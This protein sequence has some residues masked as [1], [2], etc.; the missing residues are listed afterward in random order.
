M[1]LHKKWTR[2]LFT[3][4]H[5][6]RLR[7]RK[8]L[9]ASIKGTA[10]CT[11]PFEKEPCP[12]LTCLRNKQILNFYKGLQKQGTISKN[13]LL[14]QWWTY[15]N[16]KSLAVERIITYY[17][18]WIYFEEYLVSLP[19]PPPCRKHWMLCFHHNK[20]YEGSRWIEQFFYRSNPYPTFQRASPDITKFSYVTPTNHFNNK[21]LWSKR[22]L[23]FCSQ[24]SQ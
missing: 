14:F 24:T 21:D 22:L 8:Q 5:Q 9:R 13:N 19:L 20:I 16:T 3:A 11:G 17:Y 10:L 7:V 12:L 15:R 4:I 18:N 23:N 2:Q 6:G 1:G